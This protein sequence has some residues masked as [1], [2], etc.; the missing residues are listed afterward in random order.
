MIIAIDP[1]ATGPNSAARLTSLASEITSD[2]GVRLPGRRGQNS[3]RDA[4]AN[5]ISVDDEILRLLKS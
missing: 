2:P 1:G 5:G 3:R 4:L